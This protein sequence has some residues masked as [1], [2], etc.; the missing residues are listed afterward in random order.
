MG[1]VSVQVTE[2]RRRPVRRPGPSQNQNVW[3]LPPISRNGCQNTPGAR[4]FWSGW[5]WH[6]A[7]LVPNV[8]SKLNTLHDTFFDFVDWVSQKESTVIEPKKK[9]GCSH[10]QQCRSRRANPNERVNDVTSPAGR[11]LQ[12]AECVVHWIYCSRSCR[13]VA[14]MHSTSFVSLSWG[15][16]WGD[17]DLSSVCL[18]QTSIGFW[19]ERG[20]YCRLHSQ[21]TADTVPPSSLPVTLMLRR[22]LRRDRRSCR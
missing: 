17:F 13:L 2:T 11:D 16:E 1:E 19:R 14:G 20:V 6:W 3:V 4:P 15:R 7:C 8:S 21:S 9:S 12:L 22:S 10:R 5:S 18:F